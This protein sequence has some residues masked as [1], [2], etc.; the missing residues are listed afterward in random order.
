MSSL[1]SR[2]VYPDM[3][4]TQ[5]LSLHRV[6]KRIEII[7]LTQPTV[8]RVSHMLENLEPYFSSPDRIVWDLFKNREDAIAFFMAYLP[9]KLTGILDLENLT[10][11]PENYIDPKFREHRTDLLFEIATKHGNLTQIAL[12]FEHKTSPDKSDYTQL[13]H[14]VTYSRFG[15]YQPRPALCLILTV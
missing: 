15:T 3:K 14:Y 10:Y 9:E 13:L 2:A 4:W 5:L 11:L 1:Q 7:F 6:A 12:L 8:P